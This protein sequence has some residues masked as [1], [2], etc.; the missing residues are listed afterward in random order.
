M[1]G[2]GRR[3]R[4]HAA[5]VPHLLR[6]RGKK[7]LWTG[8]VEGEEVALGTADP[9]EAKR[10]LDAVAEERRRSETYGSAIEATA[11]TT[12]A[13]QFIE[14]IQP[15]RHTPRTAAT[16]GDRVV[17]FTEWAE[18]AGIALATEIDFKIL[19]RYVRE[20]TDNGISARTVNRDLV[21]IA[22]MF[23]FGKRTG[24][25]PAN[26]I[27]GENYR[28]LRHREP[29]PAP[30]RWTLTT[31]HVD[32]VVA[33]AAEVLAPA[34]ASLIA[35]V[36]GSGIRIDEARHI[37]ERDIDDEQ[38]LLRITPKPGW[39]TKNYRFRQVPVSAKTLEAAHSFVS[40]RDKVSLESKAIWNQVQRVRILLELPHFSPH[41]LRR[42]WASG[43]H[44]RGASLKQISV[45]LGHGSL[46]VTERYV[47]LTE[48][49]GHEFLPR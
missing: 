42:A 18:R 39:V 45:L 33:K 25:V 23:A 17:T 5:H 36:A 1:S 4:K 40:T 30:N 37:D 32:D 41:D 28:D 22:Q 2:N 20:R 6:Q 35:L 29:V 34:Y 12:L 38:R 3:R 7:K 49:A 31:Q 47:R 24:V 21:P 8:W 26:P 44:E 27:T 16:Y 10:R 13:A 11:L 19:A 43:L 9:V 14:H 48:A 46:G 15:P